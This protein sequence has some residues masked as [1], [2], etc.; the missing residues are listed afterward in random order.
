MGVWGGVGG[1]PDDDMEYEP[2]IGW[3]MGVC[4]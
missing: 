2:Y 1:L 4:S 3:R